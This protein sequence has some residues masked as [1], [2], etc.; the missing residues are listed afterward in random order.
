[1]RGPARRSRGAGFALVEVIVALAVILILAAVALPQVTGYLDQ[2]KAE[3]AAAQLAV[4]RDALYNPATTTDFFSVIGN[5]ASRLSQLTTPLVAGDLD[6]CGTAFSGGERNNWLNGGPWLNYGIDA[7][8]GMA[9]PIGQADNVMTRAPASGGAGINT[10]R[11][12]FTNAVRLDDA[13]N[14]D[15]LV[16]GVSGWNTG[17][18]QWTPQGGTNGTVTLY[19]YITVNSTC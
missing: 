3:A 17:T 19:Y 7:T 12:N 13:L 2:K 10:L 8:V 9:T 1:M 15:L 14:L 16:D 4:V 6:A 18:V 5:N 11:I